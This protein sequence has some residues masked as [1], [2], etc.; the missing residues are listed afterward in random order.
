MKMY[1]DP[2]YYLFL[3]PKFKT[4]KYLPDGN[5]QIR[6]INKRMSKS[7]ISLLASATCLISLSLIF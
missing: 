5:Y 7:A 4:P 2:T 1:D 3:D 6:A